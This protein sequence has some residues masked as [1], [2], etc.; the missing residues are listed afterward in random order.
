[1]CIH[2]YIL[3]LYNLGTGYSSKAFYVN[4]IFLPVMLGFIGRRGGSQEGKIMANYEKTD[5]NWNL[6]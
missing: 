3:S 2:A 1:M 6:I 4:L 5:I